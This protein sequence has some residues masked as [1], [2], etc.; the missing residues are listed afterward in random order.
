MRWFFHLIGKIRKWW[1]HRRRRHSFTGVAHLESSAD[2]T[3]ELAAKKLVLIGPEGKP[4]WLRFACP[5][6]CG[7]VVAL[8]LMGSHYPRWQVQLH[9]DGSLTAQPSVDSEKCGS[10]FWIRRNRINWVI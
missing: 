9:N 8:N 6:G 1:R 10:H 2:P 4:K 7:Q 5:C 3:A